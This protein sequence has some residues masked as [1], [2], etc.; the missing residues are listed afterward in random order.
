MV[1]HELRL[2]VGRKLYKKGTS[3]QRPPQVYSCLSMLGPH[4]CF[5]EWLCKNAFEVG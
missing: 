5:R 2:S 1:D 3:L 4:V